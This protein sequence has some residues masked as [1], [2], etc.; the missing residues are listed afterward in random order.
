MIEYIAHNAPDIVV[1][2]VDVSCAARTNNNARTMQRRCSHRPIKPKFHLLRHVKT[3]HDSL[4]SKRD[5][6]RHNERSKRSKRDTSVT[7]SATGA[8]RNLVCNVY[9]VIIVVNELITFMS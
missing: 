2:V 8:I 1:C 9:K 7:T 5:T 6:A 4:S 3:R